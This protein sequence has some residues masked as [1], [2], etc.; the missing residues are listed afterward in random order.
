MISFGDVSPA[1]APEILPATSEP[2][3]DFPEEERTMQHIRDKYFP[4]LRTKVINIIGEPSNSSLV[5]PTHK[6]QTLA[7]QHE[8][9]VVNPLAVNCKIKLYGDK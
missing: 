9:G 5:A 3:R 4:R 8:Q 2:R 1:T 7:T 6:Q